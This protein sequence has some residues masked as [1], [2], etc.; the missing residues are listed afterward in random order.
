MQFSQK[1]VKSSKVEAN[2]NT[3]P[4]KQYRIRAD[5]SAP[6]P[7]ASFRSPYFTTDHSRL[8]LFHLVLFSRACVLCS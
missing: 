5:K 2:V 7:V 8:G 1:N 3:K 6:P 4:A